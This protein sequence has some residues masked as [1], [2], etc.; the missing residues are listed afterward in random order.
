MSLTTEDLWFSPDR[1]VAA[2]HHT[3]LFCLPHGGADGSVFRSWQAMV[4]PGIEV[5]PVHLP[6]RGMRMA[7]PPESSLTR[8]GERLTGPV[9]RRA[10]DL[11]YV[12]F[13]HSMGALLA[14]EL[15][16]ALQDG[17]RPPAAVIVSGAVPPHVTRRTETM[18][19]LPD[20]EFLDR[21][22]ALG[23]IP[24]ELLAEEEWLE[25]F[26]PVLRADFEAAETYRTGNALSPAVRLIALGGA[27]DPA[28]PPADVERWRELG[29]EVTV[30][31]FPGAHFFP[32]ESTAEVLAL[33]SDACPSR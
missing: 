27:D 30:R 23:G 14:Y 33:V 12:L 4:D 7:E 25:L 19:L 2:R 17:P 16:L 24:P 10:D 22:G 32:F 6:G 1:P 28:A 5:V 21:L 8:L 3:R 31:I 11:P 15:G 26:L 13:G 18:H 29:T 20:G 9:A